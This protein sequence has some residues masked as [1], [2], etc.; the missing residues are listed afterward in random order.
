LKGK[1]MSM[2]AEMGGDFMAP[3][4][5]GV[6]RASRLAGTY[7]SNQESIKTEIYCL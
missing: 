5:A 3:G 6:V 7:V 1:S 2:R 4:N